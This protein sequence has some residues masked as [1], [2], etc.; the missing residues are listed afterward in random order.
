MSCSTSQNKRDSITQ[1]KDRNPGNRRDDSRGIKRS[2]QRQEKV[3]GTSKNDEKETLAPKRKKNNEI[4]CY[5]NLEP[6][7]IGDCG[8]F[9][10]LSITDRWNW[11]KE[12]KMCFKCL[13]VSDHHQNNCSE[14][15]CGIEECSQKHHRSLHRYQAKEKRIARSETTNIINK[16]AESHNLQ[17]EEL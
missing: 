12:N 15:P 7:D 10:N 1:L 4:C 5:C 3:F 16:H 8:R 13:K 14:A 17:S 6:H 9:M 11:A 2:H